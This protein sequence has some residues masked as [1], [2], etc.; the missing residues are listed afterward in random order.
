MAI[1]KLDDK[2][3]VWSK[4]INYKNACIAYLSLLEFVAPSR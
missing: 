4:L 2:R 1:F 3:K